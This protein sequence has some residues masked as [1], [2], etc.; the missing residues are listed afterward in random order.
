MSPNVGLPVFQESSSF[1]HGVKMNSNGTMNTLGFFG[2]KQQ[3]GSL[4]YLSKN[5][6]ISWSVL[7]VLLDRNQGRNKDNIRYLRFQ[8]LSK[9]CP[10]YQCRNDCEST[11]FF[12][13]LGILLEILFLWER[14]T[15]RSSLGLVP[16]AWLGRKSTWLTVPPISPPSGGKIILPPPPTNQGVNG[17]LRWI[18]D[19]TLTLNKHLL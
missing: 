19:E 12:P 6:F 18:L 2:C 11:N 16:A 10:R 14:E 4:A 1:C 9:F 13:F 7:D 5:I 3:K 15:T 17:K 8:K